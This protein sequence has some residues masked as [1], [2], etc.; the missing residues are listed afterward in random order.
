MSQFQLIFLTKLQPSK[1]YGFEALNRSLRSEVKLR[2][3]FTVSNPG[4]CSIVD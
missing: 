1:P 2:Y 4:L 3:G